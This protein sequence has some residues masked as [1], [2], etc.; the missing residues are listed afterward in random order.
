MN[1][2]FFDA[3]KKNPIIASVRNE[4]EVD[5]AVKSR[6]EAIFIIHIDMNHLIEQVKKIKKSGKLVFIHVDLIPCLLYTSSYKSK[7]IIHKKYN[8]CYK[9]NYI[10]NNITSLKTKRNNAYYNDAQNKNIVYSA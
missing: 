8:T 3:L 1:T 2:V 7:H 10:K 9:I 4:E 6:A 5:R